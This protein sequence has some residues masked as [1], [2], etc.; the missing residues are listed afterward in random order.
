[1][2]LYKATRNIQ[3]NGKRYLKGAT[4][5]LDAKEKKSDLFVLCDAP[6]AAP[7]VEKAAKKEEKPAEK[8]EPEK[9][10]GF[11]GK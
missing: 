2:P 7:K 8:A 6:V 5:E 11:F 3:H 4:V 1:M 10:G 9:K